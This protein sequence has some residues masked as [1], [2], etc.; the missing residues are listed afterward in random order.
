MA[1]VYQRS[2]RWV[3]GNR[4]K[5]RCTTGKNFDVEFRQHPDRGAL[6]HGQLGDFL[7]QLRNDLHAGR[8]GSDDRR[9]AA[10]QRDVVIPLCRVDDATAERLD[11]G[12]VRHLRLAQKA[13][14]G[15][16]ELRAQRLAAGQ[17]KAPHLSVLVPPGTLDGGVEPHEPPHV[18][19]LGHVHGVALEFRTRRVHPRPV[20]V[21]LEPVGERGRRL[22]DRQ[23]GIV[24]DV[25]RS[26][27]IVFAVENDDV[28]VTQAAQLDGGADSAETRPH[29]DH[30]EL[31]LTH[32]H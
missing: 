32:K 22:I 14:R 13:G 6:I 1:S 2:S 21:R 27:Q 25:P 3:A 4:A 19:F 29:D 30:I 16:Q 23:T 5:S 11:T 28:L 12:D 8:T 24:V 15:D 18:V 20:R 31:L 9:P 26:T 17:R 7:R 10:G